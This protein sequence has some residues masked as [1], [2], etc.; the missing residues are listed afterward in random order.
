MKTR[1]SLFLVLLAACGVLLFY[2]SASGDTVGTPIAAGSAPAQEQLSP[3]G[4]RLLVSNEGTFGACP[5]PTGTVSIINTATNVA[6]TIGVGVNPG[7]IRF[8]PSGSKAY[9]VNQS[10]CDA[11]GTVSVINV[12]SASVLTT[13][14]V[15]KLP[16]TL[17]VSKDGGKVYVAN[18][19]ASSNSISVICTGLVSGVCSSTDMVIGT[20][21]LDP[22][23]G[24]QPH[25]LSKNPSGS[26]L[27]VAEQ[28]CPAVLGCTSGNVAVISTSTDTV[29]NNIT[30]GPTAGSIQFTPDGSRA[31]VA[32]R[33]N[34][35]N[36]IAPTVVDVNALSHAV[37]NTIPI[38][39]A[40]FPTD[41]APHALRASPDGS[42]VYVINK[43]A[44]NAGA[45]CTGKVPA[46]C[47]ATDTVLTYVPVGDSPVRLELTD[48]GGRAY[49]VS[50]LPASSNGSVSVICTGLVAC[51][52][53]ATD[54]IMQTLTV[55]KLALDLEI[56][57]ATQKA[58]VS[59]QGDNDVSVITMTG[60][61]LCGPD[62]DADGWP[63]ASDNCPLWPNPSQAYPV[64]GLHPTAGDSDCDGF[65]DRVLAS[66]KAAE[67]YIGTNPLR[68]CA[69]TAGANNDPLPDA[70]PMDFN[71][72]RIYS[73][74]D[75][76][77]FGG[78]FGSYNHPVSAGP[79]GGIPGV[80]FDFNGDGVIAGGD[81]GK[82]QAYFNKTCG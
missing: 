28:D 59:N 43:H 66:G 37:T 67:T 70:N 71:D 23:V 39:P 29:I 65:P 36:G 74:A 4:S 1:R 5:Y 42:K 47:S 27:W 22:T 72:D 3:D 55:G 52:G 48:N 2:G 82:Y 68:Q 25:V 51:G 61:A 10:D 20:I 30:V 56:N 40:G 17:S 64:A 80:R 77:K 58:Y 69:E 60:A 12:A 76:G 45:I 21:N 26:E 79:F 50:Q 14:A 8:T 63:D 49:V 24:I 78:P 18:K 35:A 54:T 57:C 9:V 13:V 34:G 31:Y 73:G 41:A 53:P 16:G 15:G 7:P 44:N 75:S 38:T 46:I 33:G 32:T 81:T 19:G 62:S 6:T 11:N